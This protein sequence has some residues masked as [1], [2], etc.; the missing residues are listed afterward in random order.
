[1]GVTFNGDGSQLAGCTK[2][3]YIL[4]DTTGKTCGDAQP[5]GTPSGQST[6]IA[7][8]CPSSARTNAWT[9]T[10]TYDDTAGTGQTAGPVPVGGIPP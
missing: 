10:I 1:V 3:R 7:D 2:W 5:L 8:T 4:K 6:S 9:V